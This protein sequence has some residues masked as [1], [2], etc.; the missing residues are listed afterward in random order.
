MSEGDD[1]SEV[2][3]LRDDVEAYRGQIIKPQLS[4]LEEKLDDALERIDQLEATVDDQETRIK[5]LDHQVETLIG[6]DDPDRSTHEKRVKDVRAAMI[7]RAEAKADRKG[8][9]DAG[10]IAMYYS[11]IQDLLADHGHGDIYDTQVRRVMDEIVDVDGFT[12]GKKT[13]P[14]SGRQ[15]KA[16]RVNLAALPTY[17]GTNNVVSSGLEGAGE[18]GRKTAIQ[19]NQG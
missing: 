11:E 4:Q 12:F 13:S 19:N 10:K 7:R 3:I 8:D 18:L 9:I 16:L 5:Q 2:D 1:R 17:A 14:D 6:V 15:V